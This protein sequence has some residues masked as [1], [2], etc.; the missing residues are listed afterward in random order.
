[1]HWDYQSNLFGHD[2]M[3]PDYIPRA[4]IGTYQKLGYL[5]QDTLVI[6]SPQRKVEAFLYRKETNQ[7][8]PIQV[9]EKTVQKAIASYQTAY[10]LFKN[11][12]LA[13]TSAR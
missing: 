7:Q 5:E 11:K 1:M 8:E 9:S 13:E 3:S 12:G 10:H 4:F 6:L 2:V